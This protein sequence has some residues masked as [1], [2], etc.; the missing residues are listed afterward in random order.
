MPGR[1]ESPGDPRL[2][3]YRDLTDA[4]LRRSYEAEHGIFVLEGA[5]VVRT[6]LDAGWELRSLLCLPSAL[7]TMGDVVASVEDGGGVVVVADRPVI[8]TVAGF[9]VHRGV[10]ALAARPA[11][12]DAAALLGASRLVV[13]VEG[14]N[15]HENLGAIFRNSAAFGAGAVL[16]DPT[17]CDPL[18]RRSVRVS[19]GNVLKVPFARLR[20]WPAALSLV[21][22]SGF[23]LLALTPGSPTKLT[24]VAAEL[25]RGSEETR[26]AVMVG[27][28]GPG[29]TE[30]ALGAAGL[31]AR[32]AMAPGVD[33]LNV[34]TSLAVA[35]HAV[36]PGGRG[37]GED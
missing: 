16:L 31:R 2:A 22:E 3:G 7:A 13:V 37:P 26:L 19:M 32:I 35:L 4:A 11:E 9:G 8:D 36:R 18:Y 27:A 1:V 21:S 29:L 10:L 23:E 34:A 25:N 30:A 28:E 5:R 14:V 17:S 15:D 33:S 12:R 6:A 20:P 24:E